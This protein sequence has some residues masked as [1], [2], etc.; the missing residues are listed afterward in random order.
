MSFRS[1]E[2]NSLPPEVLRRQILSARLIE[3]IV[4]NGRRVN[5]S[6]RIP[7]YMSP[8]EFYREQRQRYALPPQTIVRGSPLVQGHASSLPMEVRE[9]LYGH[10]RIMAEMSPYPRA[11]GGAGSGPTARGANHKYLPTT[12]WDDEEEQAEDHNAPRGWRVVKWS[13]D[14]SEDEAEA[15]AEQA[16]RYAQ[17]LVR[18]RYGA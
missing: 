16:V 7:P 10:L 18:R 14:D 1:T 17:A 15:A 2:C 4:K 9:R 6:V 13:S 5:E 11:G 3:R 8:Q 12:T